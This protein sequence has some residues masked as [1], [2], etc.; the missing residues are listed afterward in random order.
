MVKSKPFGDSYRVFLDI[1]NDIG[2]VPIQITNQVEN[3][4]S[5]ISR[6]VME[7]PSTSAILFLIVLVILVVA[8]LRVLKYL[9]NPSDRL[10]DVT[11]GADLITVVMHENPD[12]DAMAS[13]MAIS[14]LVRKIG[15]DAEIVYPGRISHHQNRAFRA[16]LDASFENINHVE[17]ING[18]RIILVDHHEPRGIIGGDGLVPDAVID[19]H[20]VTSEVPEDIEFW[21]VDDDVGS[22]S[23]IVGEYLEEQGILQNSGENTLSAKVSTALYQGIRSDTNDLSR[24]VSPRDFDCVTNL[25]DSIDEE[26]LF[27]IA[28]PKIDEDTLETRARAIMGRKVRGSFAVSNVGEVQNSDSIPQSAD[29]LVQLEGVSATVVFGT[30][31]ENIR[32]S[33]RAYDDR[34]HMGKTLE[35]CVEDIPSAGAGGHSEMAG[36]MIP[37][38]YIE[39]NDMNRTDLI[40]IFFEQMDGG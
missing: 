27:R 36:G 26:M 4:I 38:Q 10:L 2:W 39:S 25:Y 40:E 23:A 3:E 30:C 29:E 1:T 35:R 24:S 17:D 32:V 18:D 6:Y 11:D 33:G 9:K 8:V 19:H 13:A 7:N 37:R 14:E 34:I 12:P 15:V 16:V 20:T 5:D 28:N 21:H 22:C 31:D